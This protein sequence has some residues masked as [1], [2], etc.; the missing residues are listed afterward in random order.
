MDLHIHSRYSPDSFSSPKE[1]IKVAI[2]KK[3]EIIA[4]T[5]HNSIKGSLVS[6]NEKKKMDTDLFVV[7]GEEINTN[8]GDIIGIFLNKEI[9]SKNINEVL[10]EIIDQDGLVI[11]P[12]PMKHHNLQLLNS[13]LDKIEFIELLNSKSPISTEKINIIHSY[14]KKELGTSDAHFTFEIGKCYTLLDTSVVPNSYDE[15]PSIIRK[16]PLQVKGNFS[17]PYVEKFSQIVKKI[18]NI[19]LPKN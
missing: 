15:L 8:I 1:I 4:I 18:K 13:Y 9:K 3:I 19:T 6:F 11:L 12:H 10:D 2:K 17:P 7:I 14:N 5:D 16:Y